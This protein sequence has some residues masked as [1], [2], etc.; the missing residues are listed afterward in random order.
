MIWSRYSSFMRVVLSAL[1]LTFVSAFLGSALVMAGPTTPL[2]FPALGVVASVMQPH[3]IQN[4]SLFAPD[5]ISEERGIA[6]R[7]RCESGDV[8]EYV[9]VTTRVIQEVQRDRFFPSRESRIISNG[10][11]ER[12]AEDP[13]LRALR[14]STD[15]TVLN[16]PAAIEI[17]VAEESGRDAAELML[18]RYAIAISDEGTCDAA[19]GMPAVGAVQLRYVFHAFPGWSQRHDLRSQGDVTFTDSGW[20]SP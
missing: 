7:Y 5:P 9:D 8:T 3:F 19:N 18:A 6:A 1:G 17:I 10:I 13:M 4:W 11:L 12:F 2:T 20:I 14:D 16:S 15:H